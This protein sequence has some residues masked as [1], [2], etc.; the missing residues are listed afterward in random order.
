LVPGVWVP[1]RATATC[2]EVS[3]WQK[4]DEVNVQEADGLEQVQ[5]VLSPAPNG[6]NDDPDA[7]SDTQD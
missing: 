5:V 1:L 6:G 7:T 3:Q 4:L 2:R